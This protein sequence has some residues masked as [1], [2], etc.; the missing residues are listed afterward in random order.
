MKSKEMN[1]NLRKKI[2]LVLSTNF[3]IAKHK[4][5]ELT[6]MN[7]ISYW[8]CNVIFKNGYYSL[9]LF[10]YIAVML[11][12]LWINSIWSLFQQNMYSAA[13]KVFWERLNWV[14]N[15]ETERRWEWAGWIGP[16]REWVWWSC[17]CQIFFWPGLTA[18]TTWIC[19]SNIDGAVM[20]SHSGCWGLP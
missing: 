9:I 2:K 15:S 13:A 14:G 10:L 4:R 12:I 3:M 18:W 11:F 20:C 19:A 16:G 8:L 7:R 5:A 17:T 6:K 1:S